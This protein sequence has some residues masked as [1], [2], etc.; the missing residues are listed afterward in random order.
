MSFHE[1]LGTVP[2]CSVQLGTVPNCSS[3]TVLASLNY[4]TLGL[5]PLP[6]SLSRIGGL[7]CVSHALF[8]CRHDDV[9]YHVGYILQAAQEHFQV[10]CHAYH[11]VRV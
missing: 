3:P 5:P 8:F 2:N 7:F 6:H 11:V 9:A 4:V 1:Q 10:D